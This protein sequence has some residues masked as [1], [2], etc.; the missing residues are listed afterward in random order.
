MRCLESI[1]L[2]VAVSSLRGIGLVGVAPE[3]VAT[4]RSMDEYSGSRLTYD[5]FASAHTGAGDPLRAEWVV[6]GKQ[7]EA[8]SVLE[9]IDALA[10]PVYC[11]ATRHGSTLRV[12]CGPLPAELQSEHAVA[13]G[14]VRSGSSLIGR[15]VRELGDSPVVLRVGKRAPVRTSASVLGRWTEEFLLRP[16]PELVKCQR[17]PDERRTGVAAVVLINL[18]VEREV[19]GFEWHS[20]L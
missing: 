12:E 10:R 11:G 3:T 7:V 20:G 16:A 8:S 6:A 2:V 14:R 5:L 13:V 18:S 19:S 17:S 9:R 4:E 15:I 1:L